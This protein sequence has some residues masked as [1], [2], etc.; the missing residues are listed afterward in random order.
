VSLDEIR[1]NCRL[2]L[3]SKLY[4][5]CIGQGFLKEQD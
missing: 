1:D 3:T 4:G 2:S 5:R